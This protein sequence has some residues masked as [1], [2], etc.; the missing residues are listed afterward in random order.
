[1][2]TVGDSDKIPASSVLAYIANRGALVGALVS[3]QYRDAVHVCGYI[4]AARDIVKRSGV[5]FE[6]RTEQTKDDYLTVYGQTENGVDF[7]RIAGYLTTP[8]AASILPTNPTT[9]KT[10]KEVS[11]MTREQSTPRPLSLV[12]VPASVRSIKRGQ[13]A[14][15]LVKN[16]APVTVKSVDAV[17]VTDAAPVPDSEKSRLYVWRDGKKA[18]ATTPAAAPEYRLRTILKVSGAFFDRCTKEWIFTY[19]KEVVQELV[20][21][22]ARLVESRENVPGFDPAKLD[23]HERVKWEFKQGRVAW[24][25]GRRFNLT[26]EPR[27]YYSGAPLSKRNSELVGRIPT[28]FL[29]EQTAQKVAKETGLTISLKPGADI[30][31]VRVPRFEKTDD[32]GNGI[33][34]PVNYYWEKAYKQEDFKG[35]PQKSLE[36]PAL[37]DLEKIRAALGAAPNRNL[38]ETFRYAA[39]KVASLANLT[40]ERHALAVEIAAC[41]ALSSVGLVPRD[42]IKDANQYAEQWRAALFASNGAK[43]ALDKGQ[44]AAIEILTSIG[45]KVPTSTATAPKA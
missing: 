43:T 7:D 13:L 3:S 29:T 19:K 38:L 20:D 23:L 4:V 26:S 33:G 44:A 36:S 22:G 11:T 14:P 45:V 17:P 1:M 10:E 34:S 42:F 35:L 41:V 16:A 2:T 12:K 32:D 30:F 5:V 6:F 37:P 28:Y 39:S 9:N 31:P 27:G 25:E 21:N 40:K 24:I 8:P 15:R 18:Y